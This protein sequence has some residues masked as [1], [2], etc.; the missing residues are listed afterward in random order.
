[1]NRN[2]P[3]KKQYQFLQFIKKYKEKN[4]VLPTYSQMMEEFNYKYP[5]SVT[6]NLQALYEKGLMDKDDGGFN[7]P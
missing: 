3:T 2:E 5:N 1:M 4:G 6:Q 7:L